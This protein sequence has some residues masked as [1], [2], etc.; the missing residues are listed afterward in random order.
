MAQNIKWIGIFGYTDR[1]T[2]ESWTDRETC[3]SKS[4]T[5]AIRDFKR[6]IAVGMANGQAELLDV[7]AA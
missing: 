4:I 5:S 6:R 3:F 7:S 1:R 2:G